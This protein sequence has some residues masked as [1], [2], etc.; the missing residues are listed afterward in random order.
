MNHWRSSK[1]FLVL[2]ALGALLIGCQNASTQ[3][4]SGNLTDS[5][6]YTFEQNEIVVSRVTFKD[7]ATARKIAI[8]FEPI[9]MNY[10]AG[11]LL[12]DLALEDF[13]ALRDLEPS[14]GIT[15]GVDAAL[16]TQQSNLL[17]RIETQGLPGVRTQSIS[18]YACYRTVEET[19]TTAQNIVTNYP[20]LAAWSDVGDSWL[21]TQNRG[22]YDLRVLK[23]TNKN[24]T[25]SKPRAFIMAA[26]HAREYTTAETATRLAEYL[27]TNYGSN[28]D[29][30]W[31]L[32]HQEVHLLFQANPDGRKQ[33][34][35]GVLWRKNNNTNYCRTGSKKGADLNRN[36]SFEWNTGGSS[37]NQCSDTYRGASAASEPE[38]Q[39]IQ[40]YASSIFPDARGPNTTDAAPASTSGVFIT[41]HSYSE[42]VLWPWGNRSS[43][44][45]NG[46]ALQTLGRKLAFFNNY[47]PQQ[48]IGL[49]P[50]SGT[51]DDYV[52]GTLGIA[53][54]T[55]ELGT[56]FFQGCT[57][58][59]NTI[60]PNNLN[61]LLYAIRVARAPYQLPAG[62]ETLSVALSGST[63]TATVNDA[64][65]NNSNGAEPTQSI[66]AAEYYVDTPPWA[67][68]A[69]P[70]PMTA[71]DGSFNASSEAVRATIST[72]GLGSGRHTIFVRGRDSSG[73][74]GAVSAVFLNVP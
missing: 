43:A 22:G 16:T 3:S 30:T 66:A 71:S 8:S 34:E 13:S 44:A 65:F 21:K 41:L 27:V 52:Y 70:N 48:S 17:R 63:L 45:P 6:R 10:D 59:T 33:A 69:T 28:A 58:F 60:L 49:Y 47:T 31:M 56:S 24:I 36:A 35:A 15:V 67:S 64:R 25:G 20:N 26:I 73:N 74:R 37:S 1:P 29:V 57:D 61:A 9:E 53:S 50:T 72:S 7:A 23:L 39:A 4:A 51:T 19:F 32:D 2:G 42:L 12:T 46:T 40:N 14:L 38:T 54:Y 62:P 11:Y 18:G 55:F 5:E 68:G